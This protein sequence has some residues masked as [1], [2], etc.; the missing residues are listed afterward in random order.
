[1]NR[2]QSRPGLIATTLAFVLVST[3]VTAVFFATPA[4]AHSSTVTVL[5][6]QVSVR[7]ASGQPTP[8]A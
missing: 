3:G 5:D 1:M 8:I 4:Q 7:H 2:P 6:G